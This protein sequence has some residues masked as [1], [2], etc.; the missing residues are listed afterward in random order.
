V[1]LTQN[2]CLPF[3]LKSLVGRPGEATLILRLTTILAVITWA[4]SM[5][6]GKNRMNKYSMLPSDWFQLVMGILL[7][8]LPL[9]LLDGLDIR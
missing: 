7:A 3:L 8:S 6:L 5:F 4:G 9:L 2:L 1:I